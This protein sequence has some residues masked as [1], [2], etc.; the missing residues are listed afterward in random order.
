MLDRAVMAV[1]FLLLSSAAVLQSYGLESVGTLAILILLAAVAYRI[2]V[3]RLALSPAYRATAKAVV[4]RMSGRPGHLA[5]VL[6][7]LGLFLFSFPRA[8]ALASIDPL[9]A[10]LEVVK[11]TSVAAL[12]FGTVVAAEGTGVEA[13]LLRSMAWA[14][15]LFGIANVLLYAMQVQNSTAMGRYAWN[16][17]RA[18]ILRY[19]GFDT[20]RVQLVFSSG[21]EPGGTQIAPGLALGLALTRLDRQQRF[22]RFAWVLVL[23]SLA[24]ILLTDSRTGLLA[25]LA[26]AAVVVAPRVLKRRVHWLALV[27]PA[28]PL[29]LLLA[30]RSFANDPA[31]GGLEREG[32]A[33]VGVLSGRP[34]IW[35]SI[36]AFL[37]R[38]EPTHLIGYG[39]WGQVGS[40]VS[41]RYAALFATEFLDPTRAGAHNAVLQSVLDVGYIGALLQ[42]ALF[43]RLLRRFARAAEQPNVEGQ[44]ANVGLG[45]TVCLIVLGVT[46]ETLSAARPVNLALFL[47]LNVHCLSARTSLRSAPSSAPRSDGPGVSSP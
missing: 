6:M 5:L 24:C 42:L 22:R 19:L 7:F 33:S 27:A 11:W 28:M 23:S 10:A 26:G 39:S 31:L 41:A 29:A 15:L 32:A 36:V 20:V 35:G 8:S 34:L 47:A 43:W 38:F 25:A 3:V 21:I 4:G 13:P 18:L 14:F 46:S 30:L 17:E 44:W 9:T 40:G 2:A 37:S 45:L 1:L 16:P 12:L